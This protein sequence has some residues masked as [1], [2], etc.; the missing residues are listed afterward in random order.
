MAYDSCAV[1]N[2]LLDRAKERGLRLT[3]LQLIKLVYIS[4][5]W[6]LAVLQ[7]PLIADPIEAWDYGP[8]I[9]ALY[10]ALRKYGRGEITAPIVKLKVP[11]GGVLE[12]VLGEEEYEE[13]GAD[14]AG[15]EKRLLDRVLEVYGGL[16]PFQLS[17]LTHREGT[18]WEQ[19]KEE[20]AHARGLPIGNLRIQEH[21]AELAQY[22]AGTSG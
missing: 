13:I 20:A 2:Y 1:E 10:H 7:R 17:A 16:P 11:E 5:G 19:I 14:F 12:L 15:A 22:N 8:V 21:F 9:P 18:P 3:P 6:S 4:H